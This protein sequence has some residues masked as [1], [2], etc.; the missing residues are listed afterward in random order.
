MIYLRAVLLLLPPLLLL[1]CLL[2]A[3]DCASG[4]D[5]PVVLLYRSCCLSDDCLGFPPPSLL[6]C[7]CQLVALDLRGLSA[8]APSD[9]VSEA[10]G[11]SRTAAST[12]QT[13]PS[14][15]LVA[16]PCSGCSFWKPCNDLI[17]ML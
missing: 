8:T 2:P 16:A 1:Q 9:Q 13:E 3:N 10:A 4:S 17:C 14:P 6:S 15:S 12:E 7:Q 5:E 11:E